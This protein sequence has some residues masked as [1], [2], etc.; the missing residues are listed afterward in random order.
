[1]G[2]RVVPSA[3]FL[4]PDLDP[5]ELRDPGRLLAPRVAPGS[6]PDPT[7]AGMAAAT[8]FAL[9]QED[10]SVPASTKMTSEAEERPRRIIEVALSVE[11]GRGAG[12]VGTCSKKV[13]GGEGALPSHHPSGKLGVGWPL[14]LL[15][16]SVSLDDDCT[17]SDHREGRL[18]NARVERRERARRGRDANRAISAGQGDHRRHDDQQQEGCPEDRGNGSSAALHVRHGLRS[19]RGQA[20]AGAQR[21]RSARPSISKNVP[22]SAGFFRKYRVPIWRAICGRSALPDMS[23]MG[24]FSSPAS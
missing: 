10:A 12:C 8:I 16:A 18:S 21:S 11:R 9:A 4:R 3:L 14:A 17:S 24:T 23:R 19:A 7:V 6:C 22:V 1:M 13:A 20:E 2:R 5:G 15:H